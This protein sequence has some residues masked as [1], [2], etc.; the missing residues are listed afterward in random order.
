MVA[1]VQ[2]ARAEN[3]PSLVPDEKLL[4]ELMSKLESSDP[5]MV[6]TKQD[7]AP[8]ESED[9]QILARVGRTGFL[10]GLVACLFC[11]ISL[12][13]WLRFAWTLP[14]N[15]ATRIR[16]AY[17]AYASRLA[18]RGDFREYGETRQEFAARIRSEI[19]IDGKRLTDSLE[20]VRFAGNPEQID[21]SQ[22]MAAMEATTRGRTG[23]VARLKQTLNFFSPLSLRR[24]FRW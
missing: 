22:I 21:D 3:E 24:I 8:T 17:W 4:E 9:K 1:D 2:P 6:D 14:A 7:Q 23:I 19:G 12:K 11:F 10:I 16:R 15:P 18:D 20:L 13:L 5:L